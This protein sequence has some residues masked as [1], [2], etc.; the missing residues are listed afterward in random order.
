MHTA[1]ADVA[2]ERRSR[3]RRERLMQTETVFVLTI[4]VLCY[5]VVSG[6]VV[7]WYLAPALIF[8]AFGLVLGP[9]GLGLVEVGANRADFTI[10]AQLA[11]T[12]VLFNQA[13]VL[14]LRT[15][16]RRGHLPLRLLGIGIPVTI[17]LGTLTAVRVLPVLPFWDG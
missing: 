15:V 12:V 13:S 4:L 5:A 7:H 9:S 3:L 17:A 16:F 14:D 6:L 10:L 11:L 2:G 8:V 1:L